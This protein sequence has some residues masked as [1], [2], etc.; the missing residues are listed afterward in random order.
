MLLRLSWRRTSVLAWTV[1]QACATYDGLSTGGASGGGAAG[2]GHGEGG[3]SPAAGTASGG[4]DRGGDGANG[5]AGKA[6]S[7]GV[8]GGAA[9]EASGASGSDEGGSATSPLGGAAGAA[10]GPGGAGGA[11]GGPGECGS[12]APELACSCSAHA[13][14][15]YWFCPTYLTFGAAE[16]KCK[17]ANMHLPK[18]ETQAEDDWLFV[19]AASKSMGEYFLG[20]TD[21]A[22]PDEWSWLAG[23][24]FWS[25]VANGTGYGYTNWS[26]NE[27]NASG[28]CLVAQAN[29]PWDDRT[30]TDQRKYI[31]EA[32]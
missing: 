29:G 1:L 14:H 12:S 8:S 3:A 19:T 2:T 6:G 10:D 22:T 7:G 31:C 18:I 5:G 20:A 27:P 26:A 11:G 9:G 30:C 4:T 15:D 16:S 24:K 21:A 23:G 17:T 32:P 28:D 13:Q 25:G